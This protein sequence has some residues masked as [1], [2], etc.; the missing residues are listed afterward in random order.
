MNKRNRLLLVCLLSFST[1]LGCGQAAAPQPTARPQPTAVPQATATPR[2]TAT[3]EPT[4]TPQPTATAQPTAMPQPTAT[5]IPGWKK[6]EGGGVALWLPQSYEGGNLNKDIDLIVEGLRTLGPDFEQ[7]AQM[8]EQNPTMYVIWAFDSEVGESGFLTN[9]AVT[10]ERVL[11]AITLDT[12]LDAAVQHFPAQFQVVEREIVSLQDRQAGRLAIEF[13][14]SGV[15]GREVL[16]VIKDDGT[17]WVITYATG[18]E[19]FAQR[20]PIFEQSALTFTIQP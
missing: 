20:L 16:Y 17:M 15:V 11:S 7:M 2:P 5:P 8:I 9:V 10:T 6:F 3:P 4:A 14:V 19:E 13:N 12:Y 1:A 18:A